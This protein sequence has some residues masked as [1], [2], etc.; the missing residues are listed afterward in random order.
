MLS[1]RFPRYALQA[2]VPIRTMN[3]TAAYFLPMEVSRRFGRRLRE[4]RRQRNM[5]QLRVGS[6]FGID[7]G[8]I[9]DVECGKRSISLSVLEVIAFGMN[10]SLSELLNDL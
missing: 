2:R 8:Y 9:D 4:L 5:T 10:L 1:Q 3:D 6:E 7:R